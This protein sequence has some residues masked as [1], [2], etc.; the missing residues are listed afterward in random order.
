MGNIDDF[1]KKET[2][3]NKDKPWNK[4]EKGQ[5]CL[6]MLPD[7][8]RNYLTKFVNDEWMKKNEFSL[9]V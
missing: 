9:G 7:S 4:L 5:K 6:V 2:E 1:L 8:I 3:S